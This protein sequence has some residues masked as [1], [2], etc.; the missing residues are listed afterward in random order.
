MSLIFVAT[1]LMEVTANAILSLGSMVILVSYVL[2]KVAIVIETIM[3]VRHY[4]PPIMFATALEST[5]H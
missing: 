2:D 1:L 5:Q 3:I 4:E